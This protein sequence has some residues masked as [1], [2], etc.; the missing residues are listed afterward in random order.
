LLGD[1]HI[2]HDRHYIKDCRRE[3]SY[4]EF[5]NKLI[6]CMWDKDSANHDLFISYKC[7]W[8]IDEDDK[9]YLDCSSDI[10]MWWGVIGQLEVYRDNTVVQMLK[11]TTGHPR[12]YVAVGDN[13]YV[14]SVRLGSMV[15]FYKVIYNEL[16]DLYRN[17]SKVEGLSLEDTEEH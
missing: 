7:K 8:G 16:P 11:R 10:V 13:M 1:Y 3:L 15:P 5:V 17:M 9:R 12:S 14:P 2:A 4:D 6:D